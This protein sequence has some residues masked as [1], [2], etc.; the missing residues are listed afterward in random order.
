LAR[1]GFAVVWEARQETLNRLV[2]VKVDQRRLDVESERLRFLREAG[3]AGRMSGHAGIV[4]VH[5]AGILAD[6][7]PYLVMELC[8]GGS[9]TRYLDGDNRLSEQRV[10]EIGVRIADALAA[11]H[12]H[13]VLHRDVKPGNLLIDDYGQVGLA[14]FGLAALPGPGLVSEETFEA[15]T[16]AYTAPE[17]LRRQPPTQ[18]GDVY[19]LA[20]TLYALLS[21]RAPRWPE[22]GT[23]SLVEVLKQQQRPLKP[24]PE[25]NPGLMR[26]LERALS[27]EPTE[28]PTAAEF[29][30]QLKALELP[31]EEEPAPASAVVARADTGSP[32]AVPAAAG[33]AG[34]RRSVLVSLVGL[35]LLAVL[36]TALVLANRSALVAEPGPLSASPGTASTPA[37][38]SATPTG[39]PSASPTSTAA[40]AGFEDCSGQL[41]EGSLCP[42]KQECWAG[43]ISVF[44]LPSLGTEQKCSETHVYQTF[45]AGM[46]SRDVRRQSQLEADPG[47]ERLCSSAALRKR[48]GASDRSTSWEILALPPQESDGSDRIYRC[49]FGR[50]DR[51]GTIRLES[52]R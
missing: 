19:S 35:A 36:V 31:S 37:E 49:L 47:V 30:D 27:L 28:R 52:P 45:A 38:S 46:L 2:A 14:D 23:P 25:A 42:T 48:L 43:I 13:G 34:R 16:P 41:G 29:R 40:P 17:I 18:Y 21:G 5:D 20:A 4:T 3:A 1:G 26:L 44:D 12:A 50:G 32:A 22:T 33:G 7:R 39:S 51:T 8:P 24:V 9:L 6:D 11:T 10:R 15:L